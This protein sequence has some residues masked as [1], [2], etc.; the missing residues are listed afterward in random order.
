MKKLA[1]PVLGCTLV[2]TGCIA[3][4]YQPM[5][6][7]GGYDDLQV[8]TNT[9]RIRTTVNVDS[10]VSRADNIAMLRAAE[11]ACL[12]DYTRFDVVEQSFSRGKSV[13]NANITI[14]L[15]RTGRFDAESIMNQLKGKLNA[16]LECSF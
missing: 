16:K 9:W 10:D 11:I 6:S 13:K 4:P 3:T 14:F 15:N 7:I 8:D 5:K 2:L 1:V 12:N